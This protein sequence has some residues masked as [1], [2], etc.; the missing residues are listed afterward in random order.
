MSEVDISSTVPSILANLSSLTTIFLRDCG[1][2]GEFPTGIFQLTNL[3]SLSVRFNPKLIG[4]VPE[5]KR[6]SPLEHLRQEG[7]SFSGKL[8]DSMGNL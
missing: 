6:S 4:C 3:K 8:P 1:L 5:F 7:A 2:H